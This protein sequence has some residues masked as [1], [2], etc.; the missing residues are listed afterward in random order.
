MISTVKMES[1]GSEDGC[2]L[3]HTQWVAV[4]GA[5]LNTSLSDRKD[6]GLL[7]KRKKWKVF[8]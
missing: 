6:V 8:C 1:L 2:L 5:I 7:E 3:L 4:C